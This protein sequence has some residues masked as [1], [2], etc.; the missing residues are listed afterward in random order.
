LLGIPFQAYRT[1]S[2]KF[3]DPNLKEQKA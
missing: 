2:G 1:P 3:S